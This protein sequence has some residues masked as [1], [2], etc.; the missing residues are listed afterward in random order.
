MVEITPMKK[1]LLPPYAGTTERK[2]GSVPK[3]SK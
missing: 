3:E 2:F 1:L